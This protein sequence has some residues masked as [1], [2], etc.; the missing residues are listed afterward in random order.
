MSDDVFTEAEDD[1]DYQD[2]AKS[3]LV[4]KQLEEDRRAD[5]AA[6]EQRK[7]EKLLEA[8]REIRPSWQTDGMGI[9][10]SEQPVSL[11]QAKLG[12]AYSGK[13]VREEL[14]PA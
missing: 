10:G 1:P 8:M 4:E 9:R 3:G 2:A 6:A 14:P 7:T 11:V 5:I 12:D 13:L